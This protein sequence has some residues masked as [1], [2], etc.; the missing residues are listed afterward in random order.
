MVGELVD[1]LGRRLRFQIQEAF[2]CLTAQILCEFDHL[3]I[4]FDFDLAQF[5]Q[6]RQI[7]LDF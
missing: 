5:A 6:T 7:Q 3:A 2:S 1:M 4:A